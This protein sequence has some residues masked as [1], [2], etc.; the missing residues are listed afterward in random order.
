METS[1]HILVPKQTK[2]TQ[3]QKQELLAKHSIRQN[4]LPKIKITDPSIEAF[5]PKAGDIIK[6]ERESKTAGETV[7]YRIVVEN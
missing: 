4:Q 7:Y 1:K 6:I 3:E 5:E 2:L